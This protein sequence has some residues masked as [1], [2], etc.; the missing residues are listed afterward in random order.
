MLPGT[1]LQALRRRSSCG[2]SMDGGAVA[3]RRGASSLTW[4][5]SRQ[6]SSALT[7]SSYTNSATSRSGSI[8]KNS[9]GCFPGLCQTGRQEKANWKR[10]R[11]D[12]YP[13]APAPLP[14]KKRKARNTYRFRAAIISRDSTRGLKNTR[15]AAH[16]RLSRIH[17]AR[18][19]RAWDG[20]ILSPGEPC[21]GD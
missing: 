7:T 19:R 21:T 13:Q 14:S 11:F 8:H 17:Y 4:N 6:R 16:R 15:P 20:S 2:L 3:A 12:A 18:G 9:I 10:S 5:L 1:P